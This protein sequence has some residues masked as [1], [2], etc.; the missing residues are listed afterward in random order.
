MVETE[1]SL[2]SGKENEKDV[3]VNISGVNK[4]M[5]QLK[6]STNLENLQNSDVYNYTLVCSPQ[7]YI[8]EVSFNLIIPCLYSQWLVGQWNKTKLVNR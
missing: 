5:A 4:E 3:S 2:S 6:A 8:R 7:V 1:K